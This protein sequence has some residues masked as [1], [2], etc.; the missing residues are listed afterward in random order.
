MV[1]RR[2]NISD[3]GTTTAKIY[4]ENINS[5]LYCDVLEAELKCSMAKFSKKTKMVCQEGL[6]PWHTSNIVKDKIAKLKLNVLDWAPTSPNLN[7]ME[8]LWSI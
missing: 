2:G 8:S 7:L 6:T 5:Q 3:F 4:T 1:G